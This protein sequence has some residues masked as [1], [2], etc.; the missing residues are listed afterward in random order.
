[1]V[2]YTVPESRVETSSTFSY[3]PPIYAKAYIGG[4]DKNRIYFN[5]RAALGGL[6]KF[7]VSAI[8]ETEK[9]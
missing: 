4:G 7:C 8:V 2:T 1:M 9:A 5:P 3:F 6:D